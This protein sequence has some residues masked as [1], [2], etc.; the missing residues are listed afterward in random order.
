I[1]YMFQR[2]G[3]L[4]E[5]SHLFLNAFW[6]FVAFIT[7]SI[8]FL[9][10]GLDLDLDLLWNYLLGTIISILVILG[11]RRLIIY[12]LAELLR[13]IRKKGFSHAWQNGLAWSGLRGVISVVLA[14]SV[15]NLPLEHSDEL[16]AISF[17][18]VLFSLLFQGLSIS[19]IVKRLGLVQLDSDQE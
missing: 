9:F 8:A 17:G 15:T 3:G 14:L 6:E 13:R 2:R 18:V 7:T 19:F 10:I 12:F 1:K 16:V 5:D 4:T 11:S